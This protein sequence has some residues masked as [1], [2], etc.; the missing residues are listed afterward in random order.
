MS[1]FF[2]HDRLKVITPAFNYLSP[3]DKALHF[4]TETGVDICVR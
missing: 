4:I 2:A 3:R 1:V